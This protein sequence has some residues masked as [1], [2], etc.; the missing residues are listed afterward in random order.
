M[1]IFSTTEKVRRKVG[2]TPSTYLTCRLV[3]KGVWVHL[4]MQMS[5]YRSTCMTE[6]KSTH[7]CT[8]F[9]TYAYCAQ[10]LERYASTQASRL[11][12]YSHFF[13]GAH[14][15]VKR[16]QMQPCDAKNAELQKVQT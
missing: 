14:V 12:V 15:L 4:S 5:A 3:E 2:L 8:H 11:L 13:V 7:F 9:K 1:E 16:M 6:N 10:G